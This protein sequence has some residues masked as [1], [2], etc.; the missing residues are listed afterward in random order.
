MSRPI[1]KFP[2]QQPAPL[3]IVGEGITIL[4]SKSES[5]GYEIFIQ[6]GPEGSGP[7]PHSHDW[8]ESFYVI[9]GSIEFGCD[10]EQVTATAGTFVHLP[11]G[12]VHWFRFN[13]GGGQMISMTNQKS[14]AATFFTELA[15]AIPS[16]QPEL[17]KLKLVADRNGVTFHID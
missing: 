12:T 1:I 7:P 5:S 3:N 9:K 2:E 16:G 11:A 14:N 10:E 13:T 15:N 8:D 4:T 6:E 17:D